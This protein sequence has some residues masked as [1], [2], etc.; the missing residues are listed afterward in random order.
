MPKNRRRK[1]VPILS[2]EEA[3]AQLQTNDFY[4]AVHEWVTYA[5]KEEIFWVKCWRFPD[6]AEK[7]NSRFQDAFDTVYQEELQEILIPQYHEYYLKIPQYHFKESFRITVGGPIWNPK[8]SRRM[9]SMRMVM[10]RVPRWRDS[11]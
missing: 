6:F 8:P 2:A 4:D 10:C 9:F 3:Y 7:L 1:K 5:I 11:G